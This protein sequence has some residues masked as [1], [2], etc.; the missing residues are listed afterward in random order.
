MKSTINFL[1]LLAFAIILLTACSGESK[2]E[3]SAPAKKES[4]F[5]SYNSSSSVLEWTAYKF[6]DKTE[7]KGTFNDIKIE[8]LEN[9]EDPKKLIESLKFVIQTASVE[10]QNVER[11]GKIASKFFGTMSTQTISG[12]VKNL[13]KNGKAIVQI[14][15]NDVKKNVEGD[16]TLED[17]HFT[18]SATIDVLDWNGGHAIEMLNTI[19][20]DLHKGP[21]GVSK[22][23]SEVG[24]SFTTD[25]MSDCD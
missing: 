3:E 24:L 16:Y 23:W 15:M 8:G 7:V 17:G 11:N 20:K 13:K 5:Y 25:L 2:K 21:D 10:T 4:C 18:F 12:K 22:L 1:S 19:C 6:S 14:E 9:S